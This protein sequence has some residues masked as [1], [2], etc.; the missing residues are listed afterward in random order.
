MESQKGTL[1]NQKCLLKVRAEKKATSRARAAR[2][3]VRRACKKPK[4]QEQQAKEPTKQV[5]MP[6]QLAGES[7]QQHERL[8]EETFNKK[9]ALILIYKNNMSKS[10][11]KQIRKIW[12]ATTDTKVKVQRLNLRLKKYVDVKSKYSI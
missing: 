1:V 4:Q 6:R 8:I 3:R 11:S 9:E 5:K 10:N 7:K 2:S 12:H